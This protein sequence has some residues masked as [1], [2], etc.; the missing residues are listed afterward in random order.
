LAG[1]SANQTPGGRE[2][3][4]Q[5]ITNHVQET[6]AKASGFKM[7]VN[8]T[9]I[10]T[11]DTIDGI[12]TFFNTFPGFIRSWSLTDDNCMHTGSKGV[13]AAATFYSLYVS[14]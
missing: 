6:A 7:I 8:G 10:I 4:K 12:V 13:N 9:K 11:A 3:T 14:N 5:E 1:A 2:M